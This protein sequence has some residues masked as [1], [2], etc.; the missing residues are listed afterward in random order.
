MI[1]VAD[2]QFRREIEKYD[3]RCTCE[4]CGAFDPGKNACAYG[5][6]TEPH[7]RLALA[8]DRREFVFCKAFELA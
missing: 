1:T 5:Y 2:E 4:S 8:E 6:P 7:R 3:L